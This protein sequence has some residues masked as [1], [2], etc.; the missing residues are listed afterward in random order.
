M[1]YDTK[2]IRVTDLGEAGICIGITC[3]GGGSRGYGLGDYNSR[4]NIFESEIP[5]SPRKT[6]MDEGKGVG[7]KIS[8]RGG[9]G[10]PQV[11]CASPSRSHHRSQMPAHFII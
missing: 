9:G 10:A 3:S 1:G 11:L 2:G 7:A 4:S 6:W 8:G 5:G